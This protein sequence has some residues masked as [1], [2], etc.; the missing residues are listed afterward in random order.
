MQCFPAGI[1][2]GGGDALAQMLGNRHHIVHHIHRIGKHG[3]VDALQYV[4]PIVG[5]HQIGVVNMS[6]SI[7]L[8]TAIF[9][10][11]AEHAEYLS[12]FLPPHSFPSFRMV[13]KTL[14]VYYTAN[15]ELSKQKIDNFVFDRYF[16]FLD[17]M[18]H[19]ALVPAVIMCY[20]EK[21]SKRSDYPWVLPSSPVPL[22]V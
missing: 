5:F 13:S 7:R 16:S 15:S 9:P 10:R 6:I 14:H 17:S 12:Y 4:L 21:N 20:T 19:F 3:A 22:P 11:T 2:A 18:E 8:C 1:A